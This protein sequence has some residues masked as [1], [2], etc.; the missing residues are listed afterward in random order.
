MEEMAADFTTYAREKPGYRVNVKFDF[1]PWSTYYTRVT[2]IVTAKSIEVDIIFAD[3][4]WL[5]ELHEGGHIISLKDFIL[6]D[7][8]LRYAVLNVA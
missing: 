4:Q 5:G 6:E 7:P 3:S 2:S 1:T 8:E